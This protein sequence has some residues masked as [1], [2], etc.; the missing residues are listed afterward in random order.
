VLCVLGVFA[1]RDEEGVTG[2][3]GHNSRAAG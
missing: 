3:T 2:L 1:V